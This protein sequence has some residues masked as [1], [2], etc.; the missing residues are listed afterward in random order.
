MAKKARTAAYESGQLR[1]FG[2]EETS[3][4]EVCIA[5]P[6]SRLLVKVLQVPAENIEDPA[7]YAKPFLDE[8][9]PFP[10]EELTIATETISQDENGLRI[11]AAALPESAADDV[12]EALDAAKLDVMRIDALVFGQLR[13]PVRV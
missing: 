10:G 6:L 13:A 1:L 2:S 5:L 9:S 3:G 7:G 11:I 8:M 12:G 4:R